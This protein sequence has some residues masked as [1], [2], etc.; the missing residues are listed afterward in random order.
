VDFGFNDEQREIRDTAKSLLADRF[1][2]EKVRELAEGGT[3]DPGIWEEL[4]ELGWTGIAVGEEHGGQGLGMV[5]LAILCEELGYACAPAPFLANA[6]AGLAI[7]AAGS[8]AQRAQLLPGVASGEARGAVGFGEGE[9]LPLVA[10][11]EGAAFVVALGE[12]S[13]RVISAEDASLEPLDLIDATR[14]Y[15]AVSG[16]G[17]ELPGDVAAAR[18]RTSVA[19]AAELTGIAQREMDMAVAYAKERHQFGRPIGAY[20]AVS[21]ACARMLYDVEESR[22]LTLYAAWAADAEPQSL[23]LAAAMAHARAGEAAWE[24]TKAS[25]QVHGGI[26]FTWEHDLHLLLK[27]ARAGGQLFGVAAARRDRVAELAGLG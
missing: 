4:G 14:R 10:D 20:Q 26:G 2:P 22:S 17:A 7:A 6:A 18:D 25:I 15:S 12:A 23:P 3:Y 1:K 11:A 16:A 8:D 19:L 9:R 24:V 5:E 13:G 21:H 27:R